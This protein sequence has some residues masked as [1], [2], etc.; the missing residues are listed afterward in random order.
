M[1]ATRTGRIP[2]KNQENRYLTS[3]LWL[4]HNSI[5]STAKL[6]KF[7]NNTLAS[8]ENLSWLDLSFNAIF[9]IGDEI[10][11]F[12]NLKILYLHGNNISNMNSI[13]KLRKLL[14]L[15]T[16]TLHGNPIESLPNYRSYVIT[17]LPK[18]LNLDFSPVI[19]AERKKALPPGFFKIINTSS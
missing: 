15:R 8:S 7:V 6:Q 14:K 2:K 9:D 13:L 1:Q 10:A 4:G 18:I 16:L 12:P 17:I 5:T 3:S 11:E 19:S